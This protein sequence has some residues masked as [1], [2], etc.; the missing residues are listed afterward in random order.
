VFVG[1]FSDK[2]GSMIGDVPDE[3]I[4]QRDW[5]VLFTLYCEG[6]S[7]NRVRQYSYDEGVSADQWDHV[8]WNMPPDDV[9]PQGCWLTAA[10]GNV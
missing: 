2:R 4:Y 10:A 5:H 3:K 6:I 8:R 1:R 7:E 9:I